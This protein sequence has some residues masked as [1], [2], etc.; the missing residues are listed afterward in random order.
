[1][2]LAAFFSG[3]L[4]LI[5]GA[6]VGAGIAFITFQDDPGDG[7]GIGL[8]VL[9]CIFVGCVLGATRPYR[10]AANAARPDTESIPEP[11]DRPLTPR[12]D[13][14]LRA[15]CDQNP[16]L[17]HELALDDDVIAT[18]TRVEASTL[19]DQFLEERDR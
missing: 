14:Y 1:M 12:Q 2:I 16:Q 9:V 11:D 17:A 4:G 6:L 10:K 3:A 15:L 8:I 18:L 19:I 7:T 5:V 13:R